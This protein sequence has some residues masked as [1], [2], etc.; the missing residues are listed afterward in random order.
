M[1]MAETVLRHARWFWHPTLLLNFAAPVAGYAVLTGRGVSSLDALALVAVFPLVSIVVG[2]V[3]RHRLDWIGGMSL[4]SIVIGLVVGLASHDSRVLLVKDSLITGAIGMAFLGS[5]FAPRPLIFVIGRQFTAHD[6]TAG[7]RFDERWTSSTV[8][9]NTRKM[10]AVWGVALVCE[11]AL[12]IALSFV[13]TPGVLLAMSPV[14]AAAVFGP[15]AMWSLRMRKHAHPS[16]QAALL[17]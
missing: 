3:R 7:R 11:A 14:L 6:A 8:R 16:P 1:N 13:L 17:R 12:R 4:A 2:V 9:A 5:L 15:L 10:T